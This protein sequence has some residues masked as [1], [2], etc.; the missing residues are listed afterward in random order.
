MRAK[1][2]V[3]V[4]KDTTN[5]TVQPLTGSAESPVV[6][7]SETFDGSPTVQPP[8][9][10]SERQ[11][12]AG[13]SNSAERLPSQPVPVAPMRGR[14]VAESLSR[15]STSSTAEEGSIFDSLRQDEAGDDDAE[16]FEDID[17]PDQTCRDGSIPNQPA[18]DQRTH[19]LPIQDESAYD[20]P[21]DELQRLEE[22]H[23]QVAK[24]IH[25]TRASLPGEF[26]SFMLKEMNGRCS[27]NETQRMRQYRERC[28][29]AIDGL[30]RK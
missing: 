8:S 15:R 3:M 13:V 14:V 1:E 18:P 28:K 9:Q 11:S 29:M 10:P 22:S 4:P 27:E 20:D 12:E 17:A 19:S 5:E 26:L 23:L 16:V 7:D 21:I 24:E 30:R 6:V 25:L 2:A